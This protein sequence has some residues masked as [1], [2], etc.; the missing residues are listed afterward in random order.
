MVDHRPRLSGVMAV[1]LGVACSMALLC[2]PGARAEDLPSK[3]DFR[4]TY[5]AVDPS[6]AKPVSIGDNRT[7]G[8]NT[9]IMTAVNQA[10][11]GL[12]HNMTGRC[13]NIT[14]ADAGAKTFESHGYCD[15]VDA[16][17]DHVFEKYDYPVQPVSATSHADGEWI[18]GTGKF[19]GLGGKFEIQGIRL[20]SLTDGVAQRM[21]QKVGS[22]TI[23]KASA[24]R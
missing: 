11:S 14:T 12:L 7:V 3:G 17:G 23:E 9:F 19:A 2:P 16:A 22:Y 18:G 24:L 21:G 13:T 5:T 6:P 4:I 20:T 1:A 10:G 15:Y 8:V